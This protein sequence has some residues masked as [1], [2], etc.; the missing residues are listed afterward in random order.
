MNGTKITIFFS[1]INEAPSFARL[2]CLF[3]EIALHVLFTLVV[4]GKE[5]TGISSAI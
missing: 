4:L 3:R 5:E 1:S 2:K